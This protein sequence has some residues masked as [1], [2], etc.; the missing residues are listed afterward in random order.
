MVC[1]LKSRGYT[2]PTPWVSVDQKVKLQNKQIQA[3]SE[4]I[5]VWALLRAQKT[6]FIWGCSHLQQIIGFCGIILSKWGVGCGT[7]N[8]SFS[9][10]CF[11]SR[12]LL[13]RFSEDGLANSAANTAVAAGS[14]GVDPTLGKTTLMFPNAQ[15]TSNKMVQTKRK[16]S[17]NLFSL[18]ILLVWWQ[19]DKV[20]NQ[21][22]G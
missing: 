22:G 9:L 2:T 1:S 6:S 21:K 10:L 13:R 20:K 16:T 8:N 18:A 5:Q 3:I 12:Q 11:F 7:L 17:S 14:M 4:E 15:V 19:M